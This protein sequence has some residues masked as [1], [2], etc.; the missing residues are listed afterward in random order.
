LPFPN[1]WVDSNLCSDFQSSAGVSGHHGVNAV[2]PVEMELRPEGGHVWLMF[3]SARGHRQS[4]VRA[5]TV[6]ACWKLW[7]WVF[8]M[9]ILVFT[10]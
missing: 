2:P 8:H 9:N 5:T 7:V 6:P 4:A 3:R 1:R 10:G